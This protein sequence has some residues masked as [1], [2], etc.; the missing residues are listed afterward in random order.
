MIRFID[1]CE[2]Q[3]TRTESIGSI[4]RPLERRASHVLCFFLGHK[5]GDII[6]HTYC[7]EHYDEE[8][9]KEYVC[10]RCCI[11]VQIHDD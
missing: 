11:T 3:S 2:Q 9:W 6:D 7:E 8:R 5:Q 4:K 1:V 10:E